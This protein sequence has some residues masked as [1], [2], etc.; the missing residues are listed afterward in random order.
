MSS[1][2]TTLNGYVSY[3]GREG[4]L[5]FLLHRITGLGTLLFLGVHILD[6]ATVFFFPSLYD[7]AIAL[8]RTTAFG[9]GEMALVFCL[10]FHG[11]N[12]LRITFFDW[13]PNLWKIQFERKTII[14]EL[15]VSIVIWLPL[16][17]IMGRNLLINN[18]GV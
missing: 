5:S 18:F 10:I 9:I 11:V 12:G 13:Y 3:R 4:Q 1:L 6:T 8:Y 2:R 17:F 15:I 7:H 16:A 14:T